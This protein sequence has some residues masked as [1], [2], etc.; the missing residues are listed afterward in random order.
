MIL[1]IAFFL[2]FLS[3]HP[4]VIMLYRARQQTILAECVDRCLVK[5]VLS[6]GMLNLMLYQVTK[7]YC[8]WKKSCTTWD[9]KNPANNGM[10]HLSSGERSVSLILSRL[11]FHGCNGMMGNDRPID[12]IC[13]DRRWHQTVG[14]FVSSMAMCWVETTKRM[15]RW[16]CGGFVWEALGSSE[17]VV[18]ELAFSSTIGCY[19]L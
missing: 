3:N 17:S 15:V 18:F 7:W 14:N 1:L 8:W 9:V 6:G 4:S 16:W 5:T 2:F 10:N 11:N 19:R 12:T 13:G